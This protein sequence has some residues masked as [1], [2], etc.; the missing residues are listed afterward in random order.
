MTQTRVSPTDPRN[1]PRSD[2][3]PAVGASSAQG[4]HI[5]HARDW[6]TWT[7]RQAQSTHSLSLLLLSLVPGPIHPLVH[8]MG[9]LCRLSQQSL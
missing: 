6:D 2:A 9:M 1:R 8:D 3:L 4:P 5:I 7:S